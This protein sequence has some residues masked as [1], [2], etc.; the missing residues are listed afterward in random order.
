MKN[1][2]LN[3][4]GELYLEDTLNG[5]K[6]KVD[7]IKYYMDC[8]FTIEE[9][10]T[11]DKLFN[12]ILAE[13]EIIDIIF[14]ETTNG[15][16]I[17][18]FIDEWN[19]PFTNKNLLGI[20]YLRLRKTLEYLEMEKNKG[21]VDIRIDFDGVG[22]NMDYSLEFMSLSEMKKLQIV[23]DND[24]HVKE[25]LQ[26][27]SG[28][29][30][31]GGHCILTLFDIIGTILYEI[32]FYGPPKQRDNT[33]QTLMDTID[34][35]NLLDVLKLQLDEAVRTENYEEASNLKILIDKYVKIKNK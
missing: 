17:T 15:I 16:S 31:I 11:F 22:G 4:K 9:G 35:K 6:E 3:N 12:L 20:E 1:I 5:V 27:K 8:P 18:N 34:N 24:L 30:F 14:H 23:V 26:N 28:E 21:F 2:F 10:V 13:S 33:K 32:T 19:V 7:T 29:I 25:H